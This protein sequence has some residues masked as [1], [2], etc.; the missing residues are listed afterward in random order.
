MF[1]CTIVKMHILSFNISNLTK[2]CD[3][4]TCCTWQNQIHSL[5]T[6][7]NIDVVLCLN[8]CNFSSLTTEVVFKLNLL[9]VKTKNFCGTS[10]LLS[11]E[12]TP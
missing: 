10:A 3:P 7:M 11:L 8:L 12:T 4:G 2:I 9:T 5:N 1:Q 6:F